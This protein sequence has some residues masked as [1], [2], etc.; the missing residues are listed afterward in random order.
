[1]SGPLS[2]FLTFSFTAAGLGKLL[3][4]HP[5]HAEM[6]EKAPLWLDVLQMSPYLNADQ[7]RMAI[8]ASEVALAFLLPFFPP[9]ALGLIVI[10]SGAVLT[11]YRLDGNK[12]TPEVAPAV[13]L[14]FLLLVFVALNARK[15]T[16]PSEPEKDD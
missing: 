3:P 13:F 15:K 11:H 12:F 14:L 10:M 16:P 9:S 5:M 1:M 2:Y 6:V 8:G 4:Q 7:L